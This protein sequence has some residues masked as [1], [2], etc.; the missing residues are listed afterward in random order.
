[1]KI[2]TTLCRGLSVLMSIKESMKDVIKEISDN[3][4]DR[5]WWRERFLTRINSHAQQRL[6]GYGGIDVMDQDWD[7]LIILDA[8]RVDLFEEIVDLDQFNSYQRVTSRGSATHEWALRNFSHRT[9][10]DTVY[11]TG[12]PL[13]S[14]HVPDVWHR[15][16]ETW[17]TDFS[18]DVGAILPDA[19]TEDALDAHRNY[20]QKRLIIHYVQPHC[21]FLWEGQG[22]RFLTVGRESDNHEISA[23]NIWDAISQGH[24]DR[25]MV[26]SGY[27][28]TLNAVLPHVDRLI[29][30]LDG[31]T[32][33]T[34]DHGNELGRRSWPVPVGVY[35][36]PPGLRHEGL[37]TVPWA[38]VPPTSRR[39]ITDEGV[40][41]T[42]EDD[43]DGDERLEEKLEALGYV[44]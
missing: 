15:L 38:E 37:V 17:K 5:T 22:P 7:N 20:P 36:H 1:M 39:V 2:F 30:E 21:P 4:G 19:V 9:F 6:A 13:I 40:S 11:I 29:D 31:K 35:G 24:V 3:R 33:V 12:N 32:V 41:A 43:Q 44:E 16:I 8:C 28:D 25:E 26:C 14:Q 18:D 34:S 23:K 27:R 10:G 42:R